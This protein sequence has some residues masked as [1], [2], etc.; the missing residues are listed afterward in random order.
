MF[1]YVIQCITAPKTSS[2]KPQILWMVHE[3]KDGLPRAFLVELTETETRTPPPL[4]VSADTVLWL[5][6]ITVSSTEYRNL[7]RQALYP[8]EPVLGSRAA[9]G[10]C[11]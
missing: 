4:K 5:M 11:G 1:R 6:E 3:A 7:K 8:G 2:G 10:H 9:R